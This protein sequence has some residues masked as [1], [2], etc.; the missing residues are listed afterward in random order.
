MPI[1]K[2]D[3]PGKKVDFAKALTAKVLKVPET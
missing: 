1:A 3:C 2:C